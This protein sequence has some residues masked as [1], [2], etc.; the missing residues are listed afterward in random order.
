MQTGPHSIYFLKDWI[1]PKQNRVKDFKEANLISP[2][3]ILYRRI[4]NLNAFTREHGLSEKESWKLQQI[5]D[6][7]RFRHKGWIKSY[8]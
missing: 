3:G 7:N 6:G 8:I 5:I 2:E 1:G 4:Y